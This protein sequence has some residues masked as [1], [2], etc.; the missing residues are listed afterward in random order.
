[1]RLCLRC[2]RRDEKVDFAAVEEGVGGD[3]ND[4]GAVVGGVEGGFFKEVFGVGLDYIRGAY[5]ARE[6]LH[7]AVGVDDADH[8]EGSAW[9][10]ARY[11][12]PYALLQLRLL[13]LFHSHFCRRYRRDSNW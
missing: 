13:L 10:D 11:A 6:L 7:M 4:D 12:A 5:G 1:M 9:E 3:V 8:I 2:W